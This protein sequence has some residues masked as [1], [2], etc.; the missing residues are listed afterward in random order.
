EVE[1]SDITP[2]GWL[3]LC[4]EADRA[5]DPKLAYDFCCR[6]AVRGDSDCLCEQG[7]RL[8]KGRGTLRSLEKAAA[9]FEQA[10]AQGSA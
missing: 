9:C 8:H 6:G 4:R 7:R 2:R 5:G 10:A 3:C 1:E